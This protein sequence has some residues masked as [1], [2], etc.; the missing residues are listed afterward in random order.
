MDLLDTASY[1]VIYDGALHQYLPVDRGAY[2]RRVLDHWRPDLALWAESE[3]WPNLLVETSRRDTPMILINGRISDRSFASW[4][5][6]PGFIRRLLGCFTLCLGQTD[7]DVQRLTALGARRAEC[8]GNIKYA[9][10]PLPAPEPDLA[11]LTD[12]IGGRPVWLAASTHDGEEALAGRVHNTLADMHP[13]LLT[14]IVPRHPARGSAIADALHAQGLT[15]ARRSVGDLPETAADIY[16]ADT[17]GELGLFYRVS[18]IVFIGKTLTARGGQN[19]IEPAKLDCALIHGPHMENFPVVTRH[20][21]EH[22]AAIQVADEAALASA[23]DDLLSDGDKRRRLT[24]AA[25]HVA[26]LEADSLARLMTVLAPFLVPPDAM[27]VHH[28]AS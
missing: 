4:Q 25:Q 11:A 10:P 17:M 13:G 7:Q 20:L 12:S 24:A 9:A 22:D 1:P 14:L 21:A 27:E 6:F 15:I 28:A 2:V 8:H 26:K 19:P 23:I 3:F 5:R 16:L 18:D